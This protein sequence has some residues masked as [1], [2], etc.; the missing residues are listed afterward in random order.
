MIKLRNYFAF[1]N[2]FEAEASQIA[3][4]QAYITSS[5][6]LYITAIMINALCQLILAHWS[7][8]TLTH[9]LTKYAWCWCSA[10]ESW[11]PSKWI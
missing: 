2:I 10:N 6:R 4:H 11:L 8:Q 7:I 3:K 1:I 9:A 5:M